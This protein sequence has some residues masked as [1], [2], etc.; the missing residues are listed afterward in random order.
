MRYGIIDIGSNTIRFKIYDYLNGKVK[1]LIS[2]KRTAGLVSFK[3]NG[4]LNDEGIRVLLATLRRFDKYMNELNVDETY[5]FATASLRNIKNTKEIL[6][7]VKDTLNINIHVLTSKEE[8]NLSFEAIKDGDLNRTD[9]ILIDVGGGSSE[10]TIFENK[11]PINMVSLPVGSLLIYEEYVSLMFPNEE[12]KERIHRRV[13]TEIRNSGVEMYDKD[14]LF[15]VGGTVRTIKKLLKHL[16]LKEDNSQVIPIF[17]LDELLN[18]LARN[19]KEDYNK[20]LQIKVERIHTLVPGIIIIKTIADYFNV[21]QLYVSS[22]SIR[23]G[24]L[25]SVIDGKNE[26]YEDVIR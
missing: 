22:Y 14:I 11:I 21:K 26:L 23:E 20:V 6:D 24:V 10:I 13:L 4:N 9:G 3:E 2:K 8:A 12:E 1:N 17:L 18:Q 16:K 5:Y 19:T 7:K 15:G 25:Y